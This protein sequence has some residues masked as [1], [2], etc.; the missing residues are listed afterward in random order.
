MK[1]KTIESLQQ[2]LKEKG[3]N[4]GP[5]DGEDGPK[6]FKAWSHYIGQAANGASNTI[7]SLQRWPVG[8]R[9]SDATVLRSTPPLPGGKVKSVHAHE[10]HTEIAEKP[11]CGYLG[12]IIAL[13]SGAWRRLL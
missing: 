12:Y 3:F 7:E 9:V 11:F 8:S 4:P 5:I 6:T 2:W 10:F 1:T 13:E